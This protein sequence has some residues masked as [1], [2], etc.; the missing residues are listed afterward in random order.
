MT[1]K[2]AAEDVD[3]SNNKTEDEE[4][5]ADDDDDVVEGPQD[6]YKVVLSMR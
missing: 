2:Q 6:W 4:A 3:G 1:N 5:D